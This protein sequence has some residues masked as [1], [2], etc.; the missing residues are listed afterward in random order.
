FKEFSIQQTRDILSQLIEKGYLKEM[1]VG[2]SFSMIVIALA[3][4][5]KVAIDNQEEIA[6]DFQRFYSTSFKPAADVGIVDKDTL[7]EYYH[8]KREFIELQKREE[9]LK[10]IIKAAMVEKKVNALHSEFMNLYCKKIERIVYPKE[11]IERYVPDDILNK[12]RTVSESI[13]LTTKLKT[14]KEASPLQKYSS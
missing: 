11:K 2:I 4:K 14:D 12:I 1:D 5:G 7:E 13:I 8:V 3:E 6:L 9:E 10:D